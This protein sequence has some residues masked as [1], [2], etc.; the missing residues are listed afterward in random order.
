[1]DPRTKRAEVDAEICNQCGRSVAWGNGWFVNRVPDLDTLEDREAMGRP[2]PEG[3][4]I[5]ADCDSWCPDCGD[6]AV[7]QE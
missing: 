4:W 5:C 7:E 3:D 1:M 6:L 2:Y